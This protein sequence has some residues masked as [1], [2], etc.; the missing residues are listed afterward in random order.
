MIQKSRMN[1]RQFMARSAAIAGVGAV[2]SGTGAARVQEVHAIPIH[3]EP[4]LFLDDRIVERSE[5]LKRTLHQPTKR[6]VIKE[7]DGRDWKRGGVYLGKIVCRDS[8]GKFHMTYRY[9]WWDPA[10][11]KVPAVG[12]DKAHWFHETVG[13]AMSDDGIHWEK[14]RL[15]LFN[16]PSQFD[17]VAEFPFEEPEKFSKE[18][19][20]GCPIH[21][22]YD[23]HANG[24]VAESKRR[25]LLQV[26]RREATDPFAKAVDAQMF[27]AA[28]WPDFAGDARWKDRLT[29]A[30]EASWPPRG[31][32][33]GYDQQAAN[34]FS[35]GQDELPKWLAR[36]GRD[37]GRCV[38]SDLRS[39]SG[40][41]LVLPVA[42][43]ESKE[44][45]DWVEYMDLSATDLGGPRSGA[46]LGQLVIFHGDR[47]N[48]EYEM[49]T[50]PNIWCKGTTELRLVVSR[51][52]GRSWQRVSDKQTWLPFHD[53]NHG[54]DR[55]VFAGQ[56]VAVGDEMRL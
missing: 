7:A 37:I 9:Y 14:P 52:A 31:S 35:V 15:G 3:Q 26:G 43:D 39:W 55:L 49:P 2:A 24:N 25:F 18:N 6:G 22:I 54:F 33:C 53:E 23:L 44:A 20:L 48:T 38:S 27:Y 21:F 1:R 56:Q 28:D 30:P 17:Q 12:I 45:N 34:W 10:L 13:Y 19:N 4:Q 5:G 46:W 11:Q 29:P 47:S 50:I 8:S 42:D 32:L 40:T 41:E 51:D 16:A 36:G